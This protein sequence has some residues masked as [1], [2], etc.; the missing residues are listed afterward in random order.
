MQT[1][2]PLAGHPGCGL[3]DSGPADGK[4]TDGELLEAGLAESGAH[5]DDLGTERCAGDG[6]HSRLLP[7][8]LPG[9]SF[10]P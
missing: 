10:L 3:P 7:G 4:L 1:H 2:Q 8:L 5:E 6:Q 9:G